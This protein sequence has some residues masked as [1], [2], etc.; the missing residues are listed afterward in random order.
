MVFLIEYDRQ[1]GQLI[2]FQA[3]E[4]SERKRAQDTL[5]ELELNLHARGIEREVVLLEAA[6]E[7]AIRVTHARYFEDLEQLT[8]N[9]RAH[10]LLT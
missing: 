1:K 7:A 4:D 2:T 9:L 3:F 10:L 8:S 6:S 5:L